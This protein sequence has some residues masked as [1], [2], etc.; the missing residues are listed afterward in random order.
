MDFQEQWKNA[1]LV[2]KRVVRRVAV[3]GVGA[4]GTSG[5]QLEYI[6]N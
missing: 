6:G 2:M 3:L 5:C 1:A 4:Q